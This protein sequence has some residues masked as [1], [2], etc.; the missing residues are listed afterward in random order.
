MQ[1]LCGHPGI[2]FVSVCQYW[3]ETQRLK[4][5]NWATEYQVKE[6][7]DLCER[8]SRAVIKYELTKCPECRERE[9]M[10][11]RAGR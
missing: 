11:G 6:Q 8:G 2:N 3:H 10:V 4:H 9:E 7:V 1:W 5:T